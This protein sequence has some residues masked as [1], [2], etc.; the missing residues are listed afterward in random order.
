[1][2]FDASKAHEKDFKKYVASGSSVAGNRY[3]TL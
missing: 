2:L 3:K 1:M